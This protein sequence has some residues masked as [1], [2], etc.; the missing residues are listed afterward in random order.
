LDLPTLRQ[1]GAMADLQALVGRA[2]EAACAAVH[3]SA[4]TARLM[5]GIPD[6]QTYVRHR[7]T[8]HPGEPIM[9]YEE[10]FR[11]RQESRYAVGNGRFRGCC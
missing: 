9:T 11:E 1:E 4:Q 3:W 8:V 5:I 2:A 6:Y 10:F 7:Q